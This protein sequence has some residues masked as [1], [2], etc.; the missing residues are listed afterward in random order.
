M[1]ASSLEAVF[2]FVRPPSFE[3]LENRLR[4]RF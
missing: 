1:R 4:A 2:I 3:E